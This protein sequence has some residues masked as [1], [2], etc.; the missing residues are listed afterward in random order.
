MRKFKSNLILSILLSVTA[1]TSGLVLTQVKN[2][3]K[4]DDVLPE[5]WVVAGTTD[6][7]TGDYKYDGTNGWTYSFEPSAKQHI[8]YSLA[9]DKDNP[10]I[11]NDFKDKTSPYVMLQNFVNEQ[12]LLLTD[13]TTTNYDIQNFYVGVGKTYPSGSTQTELLTIS[14]AQV[15]LKNDYVY[16]K[17]AQNENYSN[18]NEYGIYIKSNDVLKTDNITFNSK[19]ANSDYWFQYFDLTQVYAVVGENSSDVELVPEAEG[20]YTVVITYTYS[21]FKDNQVKPINGEFVYQFYLLKDSTYY[22]APD[23]NRESFEYN[24]GKNGTTATYFNGYQKLIYPTYIYNARKF[25]M[26][27]NYL[28]NDINDEI[29]TE[30]TLIYEKDETNGIVGEKGKLD[31]FNNGTKIDTVYMVLDKANNKVEYYDENNNLFGYLVVNDGQYLLTLTNEDDYE[32]KLVKKGPADGVIDYYYCAIADQLGKYTFNSKCIISNGEGTFA[33]MDYVGTDLFKNIA[34]STIQGNKVLASCTYNDGYVSLPKGA[35]FITSGDDYD[36]SKD[37]EYDLFNYGTKSYFYKNDVKSDFRYLSDTTAIRSNVFY[38]STELN[39]TNLSSAING[40]SFELYFDKLPNTNLQSIYF[41][42]YGR[43]AYAGNTYKTKDYYYEKGKY[44]IDTENNRIFVSGN[45]TEVVLPPTTGISVDGLH[46]VKTVVEYSDLENN[47]KTY[48]QYYAF[49]IDN[50]APKVTFKYKDFG[51]NEEKALNTSTKYTNKDIVLAT[52]N[53]PNFFQGEITAVVNR[54]AVNADE[55]NTPLATE[56]YTNGSDIMLNTDGF[57]LPGYYVITISY[58]NKGG[59][60]R[61]FIFIKDIEAPTADVYRLDKDSEGHYILGEKIENNLFSNIFTLAGKNVKDSGALI[62]AYYMQVPFDK[63][64]NFTPTKLEKGVTTNFSIDANNALFDEDNFEK[65]NLNEGE[66]INILGEDGNMVYVFKLVDSAG[67]ISYFYYIYDNTLPYNVILDESGNVFTFPTN[68]HTSDKKLSAFW[69]QNKLIEVK[70]FDNQSTIFEALN[71]FMTAHPEK[72]SGLTLTDGYF[73]VALQNIEIESSVNNASGSATVVATTSTAT[74][75]FASSFTGYL[76]SQASTIPAELTNYWTLSPNTFSVR[77][78]FVG[79]K[80][81]TYTVHDVLGNSQ[82]G[83]FTINT[84][85]AALKFNLAYGKNNTLEN[86]V[87]YNRA[88][89]AN[90]LTTTYN[91]EVASGSGDA[92]YIPKVSYDYYPFSFST[93]LS[94]EVVDAEHKKNNVF[95]T[96]SYEIPLDDG[97]KGVFIPSYPFASNP[98]ATDVLCEKDILINDNGNGN[99]AEGLYVFKRVYVDKNGVELDETTVKEQLSEDD[100]AVLHR[101]IYI[102]RNGVFEITFDSNSDVSI[103][104]SIGDYLK[105]ILGDKTENESVVNSEMINILQRTASG[106]NMF[107]TNKVNVNFVVPQDKYA[108]SEKLNNTPHTNFNNDPQIEENSNIVINQHDLDSLT[109]SITYNRNMFGMYVDL[110]LTTTKNNVSSTKMLVEKNKVLEDNLFNALN[111]AGDYTLTIYDNSYITTTDN[112]QKIKDYS[113]A[114]QQTFKFK[115]SHSSPDGEFLSALNSNDDSEIPLSVSEKLTAQNKVVYISSNR[116]TLK[117]RFEE[118]LDIYSAKI[119]PNKVTIS[120]NGSAILVKD[121]DNVTLPTGVVWENIFKQEVVECECVCENCLD[122]NH[123][124]CTSENKSELHAYSYTYTIFD[125]Y[126]S[127]IQYLSTYDQDAV[128]TATIQF[129]GDANS[130]KTENGSFYST[131]FEIYIDRIKPT[132]NLE[133]LK[134]GDKYYTGQNT[135]KYFFPICIDDTAPTIF[136]G[137]D[138]FDSTALFIRNIANINEF[139]P[140][141]LPGEEGYNDPSISANPRFSELS[142]TYKKIEYNDD[143]KIP[144]NYNTDGVYV[145]EDNCY[146]EIIERDEAGNYTKYYVYAYNLENQNLRF[147]YYQNATAEENGEEYTYAEVNTDGILKNVTIGEEGVSNFD[148]PENVNILEFINVY[149]L[150]SVM[151]ADNNSYDVF[152]TTYIYSRAEGGDTLLSTVVSGG[153]NE[154]LEDYFARVV[155][156]FE[157]VSTEHPDIYQYKLVITNRRGGQ[158]YVVNINRPGSELQLSFVTTVE[159]NLKVTLP[160]KSSTVQLV[161]FNVEKFNSGW[162]ALNNDLYKTI[163]TSGNPLEPTTYEFGMGQYKFTTVDNFGRE[164]VKYMFVGT[165]NDGDYELKFESPTLVEEKELI[166]GSGEIA[167]TTIT[168]K[169]V[170]L[171]IDETLWEIKIEV[172]KDS[173][174]EAFTEYTTQ[175]I[176]GTSLSNFTFSKEETYKLTL[177]WATSSNN[178]DNEYYYFKIDKTSPTLELWSESGLMT[179]TEDSSYTENFTIEWNSKYAVRASLVRRQYNNKGELV[180]TSTVT[181]DNNTKSYYVEGSGEYILTVTDAIGNVKVFKFTKTQA[182]YTYFAVKVDDIQ[183]DYSPYTKTEL[184]RTAYYYYVNYTKTEYQDG[185]VE[186]DVPKVEMITN[187]TKGI[188]YE[189]S[190]S[191]IIT[192]EYNKIT[193]VSDYDKYKV[194]A[195]INEEEYVVCYVYVV[196]VQNNDNFANVTITDNESFDEYQFNKDKNNVYE[197]AAESLNISFKEY[198]FNTSDQGD[199]YKGNFVYA[200]YYFNGVYQRTINVTSTSFENTQSFTIKLSG[201]HTF[202]FYDASG[203][204]QLFKLNETTYTDKLDIYLVNSVMYNINDNLPINNAFFNQGVNLKVLSSVGGKTLFTESPV[205]TATLNGKEIEL[206]GENNVY[207]FTKSGYYTVNISGSAVVNGNTHAFQE[208]Y[209][210]T[211]I[212][213]DIAQLSFSMPSNYGFTI[214]QLLRNDGDITSSLQNMDSLWLAAGEFNADNAVYTVVCEYFNDKYGATQEFSFKVWINDSTP[215]IVPVNYTYGTST[216]KVI[217]LQFDAKAIY[218]EIGKGYILIKGLDNDFEDKISINELSVSGVQPITITKTGTYSVGIYNDE[219]RL[220]S[221]YKVI[222][223]TPLNTSYKI[224]I[225]VGTILVVGLLGVF[226]YIRKRA[227]FR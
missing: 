134:A 190:V 166:L 71:S 53:E 28:Y 19:P 113:T 82:N 101:I 181:F 216:K 123:D 209:N 204:V 179:E 81:Y 46:I 173:T 189:K 117:F 85:K 54:Y 161:Q 168:S 178:D 154:T 203:N 72:F 116:E 159:G 211:I 206:V 137:S 124:A 115:V 105:I 186:F 142:S 62:T 127:D 147:K 94:D 70:N 39:Q 128:Y 149:Q 207:A 60:K 205:V 118:T 13:S 223:S 148:D 5:G 108:T 163:I 42:Y 125:N 14:N 86:N 73:E 64:S 69:G 32:S 158:D 132:K 6:V 96:R 208:T 160:D 167:S 80:T 114:N 41:D 47:T 212:N 145:F 175:S 176:S 63:V 100:I 37:G 17:Y 112:G 98:S 153:T 219:D 135:N 34:I 104:N 107:D 172:L 65:Y 191:A 89:N 59:G 93:Y 141:L 49:I 20:L 170:N 21:E 10:D 184:N 174:W 162:I 121:G 3:T 139:I 199:F 97:T 11:T 102:D 202:K 8:P 187:L 92:T 12:Q 16:E 78:F 27:Y 169:N 183:I 83:F 67:N 222:K 195:T 221:S 210:F 91:S 66:T 129:I 225:I 58:G 1:L 74:K 192:D 99:T 140:S 196:Y 215:V 23:L 185:E 75:S 157:Q 61:D 214:K 224:I 144:A 156:T 226:I 2:T 155:N 95:S 25:N 218:D 200:D 109:R 126:N 30:F 188:E 35:V 77:Q 152:K 52:W 151:Y 79:S 18:N 15:F 197:S 26:S 130:F 136:D 40:T 213:K 56:F 111:A 150:E 120:K 9:Y 106:D 50:T 180:S 165:S 122:E 220:I 24:K 43:Y 22:E 55:R 48:T 51:S 31:I 119:N 103:I 36:T 146:Y 4:A 76:P 131:T 87:D 38:N 182:T 45:P 164:N 84:D 29:T 198:N 110:S 7:L 227:R 138:K 194:F 143:K 177:K 57:T 201:L 217:N 133:M 68:D 193:A 171:T 90:R 88:Y 44:T 33:V